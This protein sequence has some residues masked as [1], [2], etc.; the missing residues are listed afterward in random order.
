MADLT[1]EE[2]DRRVREAM[3]PPTAQAGQGFSP[4]INR[5]RQT[6]RQ[7]RPMPARRPLAAS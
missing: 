2:F 3:K 4:S 5:I 1:H 7:R 6:A